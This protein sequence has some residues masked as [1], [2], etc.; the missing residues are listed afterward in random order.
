MLSEGLRESGEARESRPEDSGAD[1]L[2][3]GQLMKRRR[4]EI[5]VSYE[6]SF[7]SS[8]QIRIALL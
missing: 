5:Y 4:M 8:F 2:G 7:S 6:R 3:N 1:Y